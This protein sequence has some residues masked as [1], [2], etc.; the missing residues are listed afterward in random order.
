VF[1]RV[2]RLVESHPVALLALCA[3]RDEVD[4]PEESEPGPR[5]AEC[6]RFEM[7]RAAMN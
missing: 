4:V 1:W 6:V 7:Q 5:L 3:E 2:L